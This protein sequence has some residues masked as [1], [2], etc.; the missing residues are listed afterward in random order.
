MLVE[1]QQLLPKMFHV[2]KIFHLFQV[3]N[4]AGVFREL[5]KP[6][7]VHLFTKLNTYFEFDYIHL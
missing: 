1:K 6:H 7:T 4:P 3:A 2:S 5:H